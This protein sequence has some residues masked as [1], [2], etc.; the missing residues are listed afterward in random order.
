ME[1]LGKKKENSTLFCDI[2][3]VIHLE[4]LKITHP[5]ILRLSIYNSCA[6]SYDLFWKMDNCSWKIYILARIFQ[7]C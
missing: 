7:T 6:I 5:S 4:K 2:Q 3:S 1:E